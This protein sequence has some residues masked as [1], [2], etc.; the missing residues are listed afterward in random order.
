LSP[1]ARRAADLASREWY[2]KSADVW[3][4]WKRR[5][6]AT[7]ESELERRKVERLLGN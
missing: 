7:P 2:K 4:E 1:S 3:N 5:G 6:A